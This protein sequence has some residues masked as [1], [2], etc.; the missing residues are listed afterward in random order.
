MIKQFLVPAITLIAI[1]FTGSVN[2]AT[3]T[4]ED[5]TLAPN[6]YENGANLSPAGGFSS[7]GNYFANSY[8]AE[9]GSWKGFAYSDVNDTTTA[10][11]TNQYAAITG[12]GVGGS[13]NYA[14]TFDPYFGDASVTLASGQRPSSVYITN[15]TYA[16]LSMRDGDPFGF[17]KKFGGATGADEDFFTI[18]FTGLDAGGDV[19][20]SVVFALADFRG[21]AD[22]IVSDWTFVDLSPLGDAS[23]ISL[24]YASSDVGI[25]GINTPLYAAIDNLVA[26]PE[27]SS[28]AIA[29]VLACGFL[30]RRRR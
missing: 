30:A 23:S 12:G 15:T 25:Y 18:T 5:L 14:V 20:G 4:F 13:G 8:N 29:S 3:S 28:I 19:T 16:Y 2:A 1:G 9:Y 7:G 10:G 6:S 27:P 24:S 17:S 11:Y 22:Y 26:V 21:D